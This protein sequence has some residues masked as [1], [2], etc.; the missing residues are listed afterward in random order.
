MV[1]AFTSNKK[2]ARSGAATPTAVGD[3]ADAPSGK[4][5]S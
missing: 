4:A 3:W 1:S 5:N 2:V